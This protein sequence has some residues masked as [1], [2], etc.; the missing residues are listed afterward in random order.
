MVTI[1]TN[2][3]TER[4]V[5]QHHRDLFEMSSPICD[6]AVVIEYR[7]SAERLQMR[8]RFR[9]TFTHEPIQTDWRMI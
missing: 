8:D 9:L 1:W 2:Y 7:P 6:D 3:L 5:A 4:D